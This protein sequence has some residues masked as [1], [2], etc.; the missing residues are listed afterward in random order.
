VSL[1]RVHI[2]GFE[3]TDEPTLTTD[4]T[5]GIK[6]K[7]KSKKDKL[8]EAAALAKAGAKS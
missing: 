2:A 3:P 8:R 6:G 4:T 1:E 5:G 7:R